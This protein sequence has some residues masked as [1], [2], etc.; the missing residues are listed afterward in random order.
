MTQII[1]IARR[2]N[3]FRNTLNKLRIGRFIKTNV[4]QCSVW[5]SCIKKLLGAACLCSYQRFCWPLSMTWYQYRWV[6]NPIKTRC[7]YSLN[8]CHSFQWFPITLSTI[9]E[10]HYSCTHSL[11]TVLIWLYL[12]LYAAHSYF[13]ASSTL[14]LYPWKENNILFRSNQLNQ[15]DTSFSGIMSLFLDHLCFKIRQ[16]KS[17]QM[18][19]LALFW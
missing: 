9:P 10:V 1:S 2:V 13:H 17:F 18:I 7:F 15:D 12:G 3:Q 16:L 8:F 6:S 19:Q 5:E 14:G 4:V 11:V